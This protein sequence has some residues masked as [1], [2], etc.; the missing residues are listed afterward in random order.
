V[1]TI[2]GWQHIGRTAPLDTPGAG[3]GVLPWQE[4]TP[5]ESSG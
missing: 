4:E 3:Q 2:A 5:E 1:A